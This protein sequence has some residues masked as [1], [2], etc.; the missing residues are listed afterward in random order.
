MK[1]TL[2]PTGTDDA[3]VKDMAKDGTKYGGGVESTV[4]QDHDEVQRGVNGDNL[5]DEAAP[6]TKTERE[7][8]LVNQREIKR[9]KERERGEREMRRNREETEKEQSERRA[10]QE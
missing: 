1:N 2:E 10:H 8:N 3:T 4:A 7:K 6:T 9:E 5:G